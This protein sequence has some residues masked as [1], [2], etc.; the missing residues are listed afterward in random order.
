[1]RASRHAEARVARRAAGASP[2]RHRGCRRPCV[3][4][5]SGRAIAPG[6]TGF[7]Q[8]DLD[9]PIGALHGDRAV[10]RDHAARAPR[11]PAAGSSTRWRRAAVAGSPQRLALLD[12]NDPEPTRRRRCS[13]CSRSRA[14]VELRPFALAR[15]L[16]PAEL[17]ALTDGAAFLRVGP[18]QSAGRDYPRAPRHARR[19]DRDG[20][21]RMRTRPSPTCSARP[22]PRCSRNCATWRR[23]RRSTRRWPSSPPTGSAVREGGDVAAAR[24]SAAAD[25]RGRATVGAGCARCSPR[26]NCARRGCARS[27]RPLALEPEAVERF[28]NRVER[29]RPGRQ[30]RR[31]PLFSAGNRGAPRRDRP[32]SGRRRR[33]RAPSPPSAFKDRT[34]VG[35]NLTIQILEYLDRMGV[36]RRVGDARVVAGVWLRAMGR[37]SGPVSRAVFKT[38]GGREGVPGRFN[39]CLFRQHIEEREWVC[40]SGSGSMS[41]AS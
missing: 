4:V 9:Q 31:Q 15:N 34:G 10:L 33:R 36:T 28:L 1:M 37:A 38:V 16:T 22:E 14:F 25:Q 32:R 26:P 30:G 3:A 2:S 21:R 40:G 6:E 27:P 39:S 11:S 23:R 20:A 8:I 7:V 19:Q 18:A 24:A 41:G 17:D 12:R 13:K 35:R 29:L 5:L